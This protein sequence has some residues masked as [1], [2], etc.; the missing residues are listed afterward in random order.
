[1]TVL[2]GSPELEAQRER[3]QRLRGLQLQQLEH[4]YSHDQR[5]LQIKEKQRLAQ[6]KAIEARFAD[7]E[8]FVNEVMTIEPAPT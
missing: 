2:L 1:M 3:L 6:R 5:P 4:S 7:H 8:R